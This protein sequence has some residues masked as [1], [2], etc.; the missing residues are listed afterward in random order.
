VCP[1]AQRHHDRA[2]AVSTTLR[3]VGANDAHVDVRALL[4]PAAGVARPVF[5]AV[6][7][8]LAVPEFGDETDSHGVR[9]RRVEVGGLAGITGWLAHHPAR[10][11]PPLRIARRR[12]EPLLLLVHAQFRQDMLQMIAGRGGADAKRV[13]DLTIVLP[14]DGLP[15]WWRM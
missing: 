4:V 14:G 12:P 8:V 15:Q 6:D 1:F 3:P 10:E 11:V 2:Q 5:S 7:H 13:G 9:L